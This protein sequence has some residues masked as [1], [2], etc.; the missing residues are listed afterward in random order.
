MTYDVGTLLLVFEFNGVLA[1]SCCSDR[2]MK[3]VIVL[4][5]AVMT[6]SDHAISRF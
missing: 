5:V 4:S 3:I 2:L 6:A 1:C